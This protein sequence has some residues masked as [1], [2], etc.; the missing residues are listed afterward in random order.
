MKR[1]KLIS[2]NITCNTSLTQMKNKNG[3]NF[4]KL[5]KQTRAKFQKPK[6]CL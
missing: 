6:Q 1:A 3:A 4:Q 2:I 5:A